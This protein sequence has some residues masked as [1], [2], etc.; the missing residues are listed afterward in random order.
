MREA[1]V[2][3]LDVRDDLKQKKEPF[4]KIMQAVKTLQ[5][6]DQLILHAIFKP[7][8]LLTL[9]KA[10][11]FTHEVQQLAPRSLDGHFYETETEIFIGQSF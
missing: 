8:P 1:K 3:E 7:T 4:Q 9:L 10:K 5:E 2:V 11:G 6:G